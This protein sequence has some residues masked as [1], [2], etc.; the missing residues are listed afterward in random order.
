MGPDRLLHRMSRMCE[1]L[2]ERDHNLVLRSSLDMW[3][4]QKQRL[5]SV[6]SG[7]EVLWCAELLGS[8]F[9]FDS[10]EDGLWWKKK[11]A[12]GDFV[13]TPCETFASGAREED[14]WSASSVLPQLNLEV[15]FFKKVACQEPEMAKFCPFISVMAALTC[16]S[17]LFGIAF[18]VRFRGVLQGLSIKLSL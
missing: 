10:G 6:S 9:R 1:I 4:S 5:R 3:F 14:G 13:T 8:G 2:F 11:Q 16:S 7:K 17:I 15:C 18:M 12:K